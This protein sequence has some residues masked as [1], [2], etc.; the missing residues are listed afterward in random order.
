MAH[1]FK[2]ENWQ[3]LLGAKRRALL[4]PDRFLAD[5]DI[6]P[7]A[8]VADLGAGPGFFTLPLAKRVGPNGRV[9]AIDVAPEMIAR[10]QAHSLPAYVE[11]LLSEESRIPLPD[12]CVDVAL[13][14][15]VLHELDNPQAFLTDVRR[16]MRPDGRLIVLE[17]VRQ[18]EEL[19]PPLGERIAPET[20]HA[21][22]AKAEWHLCAS[23]LANPSNYYQVYNVH[24]SG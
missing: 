5:F 6:A 17:W 16:A 2:P 18:D 13:L 15:F 22:L 23:G 4:E 11:A 8:T 24:R 19:G 12:G 3:R 20:S 1:K 14:A 21:M 10:L 9:Y 7:G